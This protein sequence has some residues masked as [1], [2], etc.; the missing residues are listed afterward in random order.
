[1]RGPLRFAAVTS[2]P[3]P[4][5]DSAAIGCVGPIDTARPNENALVDPRGSVFNPEKAIARLAR[6]PGLYAP[7]SSVSRRLAPGQGFGIAA[8]A[9]KRILAG[10]RPRFAESCSIDDVEL[11]FAA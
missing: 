10:L 7:F 6:Q 8:Q 9:A 2:H 1:M 5:I 11:D 4:I 3:M